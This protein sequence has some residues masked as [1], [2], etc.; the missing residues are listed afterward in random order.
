MCGSVLVSLQAEYIYRSG[1]PY[2]NKIG[3]LGIHDD[4]PS[5]WMRLLHSRVSI[6]CDKRRVHSR[7]MEK[8]NGDRCTLYNPFDLANADVQYHI[9]YATQL[10]FYTVGGDMAW[11]RRGEP[12]RRDYADALCNLF[13]GLGTWGVT[14]LAASGI[15]GVGAEDCVSAD[16][17]YQFIPIFL[18]SY[19]CGIL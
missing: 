7:P 15:D 3:V 5:Q 16:E 17:S 18:S 13:A 4:Y 2:R 9:V 6:R 19:T 8:W 14:V 1:V 11:D 12:I 10:V